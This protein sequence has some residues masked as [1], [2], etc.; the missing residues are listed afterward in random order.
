MAV[1]EAH[2]KIKE[3]FNPKASQRTP[4][5]NHRISTSFKDNPT[6][7][8]KTKEHHETRLRGFF[9]SF[10]KMLKAREMFI[11]A[12]F[13]Q[14]KK[15]RK[16]RNRGKL[17]KTTKHQEKEKKEAQEVTHRKALYILI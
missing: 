11:R 5:S 9:C 6:K 13:I 17:T 4:M 3:Q 14:A 2:T 10:K 8:K 16:I 7:I 1:N 12:N 15:L